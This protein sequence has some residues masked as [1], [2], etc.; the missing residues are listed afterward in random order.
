MPPLL[1]AVIFLTVVVAAYLG[2]GL[3]L[4][5]RRRWCPRCGRKGLKL[6]NWFRCNPPPN[7]SYFACNHCGAE[8]VQIERD[9]GVESSMILRVGSPWEHCSGWEAPDRVG[10]PPQE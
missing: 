2:V 3:A 10:S 9:D 7:R 4:T 5:R 1:L 6:I 8:F